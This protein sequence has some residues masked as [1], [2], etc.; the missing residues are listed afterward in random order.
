[1]DALLVQS[2]LDHPGVYILSTVQMPE[3]LIVV[4]SLEGKLRAMSLDQE[5]APDR[6][7]P[8]T[9]IRHGPLT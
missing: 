2:M 6:F 1:M 8:G 4:V 3:I 9:I 5:L 7:N